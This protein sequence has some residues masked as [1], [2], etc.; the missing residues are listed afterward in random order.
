MADGGALGD[1]SN[2]LQL[3]SLFITWLIWMHPAWVLLFLNND[4]GAPTRGGALYGLVSSVCVMLY[5]LNTTAN[6]LYEWQGSMNSSVGIVSLLFFCLL[7]AAA[8][9]MVIMFIVW[10]RR[11]R[12]SSHHHNS[13][14]RPVL[15]SACLLVV[16][17]I[18]SILASILVFVG[19][20]MQQ[21][22]WMVIPLWFWM[23]AAFSVIPYF[24]IVVRAT[25]DRHFTTGDAVGV[26]I[27]SALC[28]LS[29]IFGIVTIF[30]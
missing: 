16:P 27:I 20:C 18:L 26:A 7:F 13:H 29:G 12:A 22:S 5:W 9:L 25:V 8:L 2:T 3:L 11:S 14:N 10:I 4:G 19:L 23:F 6:T 28:C 17:F 30:R 15:A 24:F 21:P 1:T